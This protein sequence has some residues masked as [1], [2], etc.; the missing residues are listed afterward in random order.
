[1]KIH[2]YERVYLALCAVLIALGV[3]AVGLSVFARGIHLPSPHGTIAA[4]EAVKTPPFDQLGLT[5]TSPGSYQMVMLGQMW[6]WN[7][8]KGENPSGKDIEIPAG[9]TVTFTI[10]SS[11]VVHGFMV[12]GTNINAMVIPGQIT[13]VTYTFDTP[14]EYLVI[15]HEYCGRFHHKMWGKVIV[16]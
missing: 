2:T 11:D 9:S 3:V 8:L 10:T 13:E 16:S 4:A 5:E 7:P 1:M 15:C 14:G 6:Q 12:R